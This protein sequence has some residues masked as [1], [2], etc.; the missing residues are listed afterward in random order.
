MSYPE[1][2]TPAQITFATASRSRDP[3][4]IF[5]WVRR[6]MGSNWYMSKIGAPYFVK[7]FH[8]FGST[9]TRPVHSHL[10]NFDSGV[11]SHLAL[12]SKKYPDAPCT[13][14]EAIIYLYIMKFMKYLSY[15]K[16]K[17]IFLKLRK[18]WV[19]SYKKIFFMKFL[20]FLFYLQHFEMMRS[21]S[22]ESFL[23]G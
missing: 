11:K 12:E 17:D 18:Y 22:S 1:S 14:A 3:K 15:Q 20:I 5:Y 16:T 2:N 13:Q 7:V 8:N 10:T 21:A 6:F 23:H 4:P 19:F 9:S